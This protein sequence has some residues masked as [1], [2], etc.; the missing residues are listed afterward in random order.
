MDV[1]PGMLMPRGGN[2]GRAA[3]GPPGSWEL[4]EVQ[5]PPSLPSGRVFSLTPS[6]VIRL[7]DLDV[8]VDNRQLD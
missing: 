3:Y 5:V 6:E 4:K 2:A 8:Q 7:I 1:E